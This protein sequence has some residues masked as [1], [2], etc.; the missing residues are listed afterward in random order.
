[1]YPS[2][3]DER[4]THTLTVA[5][6]PPNAI[7]ACD[8]LSRPLFES[9]HPLALAKVFLPASGFHQFAR[10]VLL[11]IRHPALPVCPVNDPTA[12]ATELFARSALRQAV[13]RFLKKHGIDPYELCRPPTP[14]DNSCRAFCP[15]C[16]AQFT[17]LEATCADCGGLKLAAFGKSGVK[18]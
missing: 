15:R 3:E 8:S 12:G 5:L 2:A 11:D 9:F 18:E 17:T 10:E 16:G 14:T 1:L 7:R 4:F 13:E 6:S